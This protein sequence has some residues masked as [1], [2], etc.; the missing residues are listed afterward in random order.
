MPEYKLHY[1]S[2]RARGEP[3]RV[4]FKLA[5]V[6]YTEVLYDWG[7]QEWANAKKGIVSISTRTIQLA[8]QIASCKSLLDQMYV[9]EK[10]QS[11]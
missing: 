4:M 3:I 8:R 9:S 2:L 5:G 11:L 6:K 7:S 1:F 10:V